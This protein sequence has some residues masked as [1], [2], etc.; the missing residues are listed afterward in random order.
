MGLSLPH[1]IILALVVLGFAGVFGHYTQ[2]VHSQAERSQVLSTLGA[3]RTGL[4][5]H[6]LQTAV[7]GDPPSAMLGDSA[8]PFT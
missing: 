8:N 3:L 7:Q 5:I 6:H 4:V 2:R 1:L